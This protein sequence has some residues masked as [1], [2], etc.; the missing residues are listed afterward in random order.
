MNLRNRRMDEEWLFLQILAEANESV[1]RK[2][3]RCPEEFRVV[4]GDS[5]AWV[6]AVDRPRVETEHE[7]RYV[8]PRYYPT[9]PLEG[10][11]VRPI[12]HVNVN[13]ATGFVCLW[14][15][16]YPTLTVVDAILITRAIMS[17]K[18]ANMDPEHRM[19]QPLELHA[20]AM[21]EMTIPLSCCQFG[22]RR[23]YKQRLS[24]DFPDHKPTESDRAF[25]H[26][27]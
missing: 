16:Y 4:L 23:R 8:Y 17:G 2:A 9:L 5:P 18:T 7:V 12:L 6:G 26:I 1:V 10:Y 15:A 25:S 27:K 3:V 11:F 22:S 20:L 19:Q 24:T 14:R 13:P 21:S